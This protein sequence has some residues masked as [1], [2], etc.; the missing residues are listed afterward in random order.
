[1]RTDTAGQGLS[2]VGL[3]NIGPLM[4]TGGVQA[5]AGEEAGTWRVDQRA[6]TLVDLFTVMLGA[7]KPPV[8]TQTVKRKRQMSRDYTLRYVICVSAFL[9][10]P[11]HNH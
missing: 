10:L 1:M 8:L 2:A 9:A 7:V 11:S 3:C 6:R 4:L 5:G